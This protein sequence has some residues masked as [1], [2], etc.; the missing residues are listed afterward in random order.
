MVHGNYNENATI[1]TNGRFVKFVGSGEQIISRIG[2]GTVTFSKVKVDKSFNDTLK[3]SANPT[4]LVVSDSL[5][6]QSG[7]LFNPTTIQ[8]ANNGVLHS[9]GGE[10]S[11]NTGLVQ[12]DGRKPSPARS[13]SMMYPCMVR[14]ISEVPPISV[15]T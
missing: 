3:I 7:V 14:S 8:L 6:L 4:T 10:L 5:V 2:G 12:F 15:I 9:A 11:D 1:T 13:L